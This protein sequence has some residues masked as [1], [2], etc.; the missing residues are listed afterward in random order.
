[1]DSHCGAN[2]F[3][4]F[5]APLPNNIAYTYNSHDVT[6]FKQLFLLQ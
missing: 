1:M 2:F 6:G 5:C 3:F 4:P